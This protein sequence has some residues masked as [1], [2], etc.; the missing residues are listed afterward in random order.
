MAKDG[1]GCARY[2]TRPESCRYF[3]CAWRILNWPEEMRPDKSGVMV[4]PIH[5]G[6]VPALR[7]M[8]RSLPDLEKNAAFI[9]E[10]AAQIKNP[11]TM[12]IVGG[13]QEFVY[14]NDAQIKTILE[15]KKHLRV[16]DGF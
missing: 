5:E 2:D 16:I 14:G 6:P 13:K 11:V 3:L 15:G 1:S 12:R 10:F 9:I 8:A 7:V 4:Y